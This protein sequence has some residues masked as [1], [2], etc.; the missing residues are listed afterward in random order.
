LRSVYAFNKATYPIYI[1]FHNTAG[2]PTAGSGVVFGVGIQAGTHLSLLLPGGG[3]AFSTGLA[4][5]VVKDITDAG[6]TAV[7]ASDAVIEVG[8]E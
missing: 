3:R 2:A 6:T 5:T 1:K 8:Y 4:M 7:A